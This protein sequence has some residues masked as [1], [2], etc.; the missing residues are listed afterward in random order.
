[1]N[2]KYGYRKADIVFPYGLFLL[3]PMIVAFFMLKFP[4]SNSEATDSVILGIF[5]FMW[6]LLFSIFLPIL[7]WIM[8]NIKT[9]I[10]LNDIGIL[11]K[12]MFREVL[13][14]WN[15]I[16][17]ID[18]KY[19]YEGSYP[20]YKYTAPSDLLI[21]GA[22]GKKMQ[23]Y[24]ILRSLDGQEGIT[25]FEKAIYE[26]I[27]IN[28][29]PDTRKYERNQLRL[30][31]AAGFLVIVVG[32]VFG[33]RPPQH[34]SGLLGLMI[35]WLGVQGTMIFMIILGCFVIASFLYKLRKST[36]QLNQEQNK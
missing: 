8:N 5:I 17:K 14:K 9:V 27:D 25:E 35:G 36:K 22:D 30:G 32:I 12:D 21:Y 3:I 13:I 11:K 16:T 19:L 20:R 34:G 29:R 2:K 24:K 31:I 23:I 18:K 4:I 7:L 6:L 1:M 15:E 33:Y 28:K 26:R 10:M